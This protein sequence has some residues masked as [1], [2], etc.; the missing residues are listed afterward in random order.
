MFRLWNDVIRVQCVR[1]Q[2]VKVGYAIRVSTRPNMDIVFIVVLLVRNTHKKIHVATLFFCIEFIVYLLNVCIIEFLFCMA[3]AIANSQA[4]SKR[5][6]T[7]LDLHPP[8]RS[9][10]PMDDDHVGMVAWSTEW[11]IGAI[12]VTCMYTNLPHPILAMI[13]EYCTP[14]PPISIQ[15]LNLISIFG[16]GTL[17]LTFDAETARVG[18]L[19]VQ[20][21]KEGREGDNI[22]QLWDL[23]PHIDMKLDGF[24][25]RRDKGSRL[26]E[27]KILTRTPFDPIPSW[28][29]T[30]YIAL[31]FQRGLPWPPWSKPCYQARTC[32][33]SR[34]E[35]HEE[36][37]VDPIN[38][39]ILGSWNEF[40]RGRTDLL[41][42]TENSIRNLV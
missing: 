3:A 40:G 38:G 15:F 25:A 11:E 39:E 19:F 29:K 28:M 6:S 27:G 16:G 36:F 17:T 33:F 9:H 10:T 2:N 30:P 32:D 18:D 34:K 20:F 13:G 41:R 8:K 4:G 14:P 24:L 7:H 5:K 31:A 12:G 42:E 22:S 35:I 26:A 37:T 1:V 21:H 23:L